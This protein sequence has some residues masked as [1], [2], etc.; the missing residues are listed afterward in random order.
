[1]NEAE[2]VTVF[3][4]FIAQKI[5]QVHAR[6]RPRNGWNLDVSV[7]RVQ[8]VHVATGLWWWWRECRRPH[9]LVIAPAAFCMEPVAREA[10]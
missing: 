1:M 4:E 6:C 8:F 9:V 7:D 10:S 5:L 2:L 3:Q